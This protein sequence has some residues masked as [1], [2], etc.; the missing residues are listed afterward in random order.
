MTFTKIKTDDYVRENISPTLIKGKTEIHSTLILMI[1]KESLLTIYKMTL[2]Y[3]LE[4]VFYVLVG[5]A[6]FRF[7]LNN[8]HTVT[9][10]DVIDLIQN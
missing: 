4:N 1:Y 10:C 2:I 9:K 5:A 7:V 6:L 8:S 3:L